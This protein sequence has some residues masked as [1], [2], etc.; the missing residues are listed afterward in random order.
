MSDMPCVT[1]DPSLLQLYRT[2][3]VWNRKVW[4]IVFPTFSTLG[5]I[6]KFGVYY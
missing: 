5:L 2:W 1:L 3:I 4:T 6:G